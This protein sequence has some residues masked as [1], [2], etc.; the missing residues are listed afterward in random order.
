MAM[1][2]IQFQA[3][4]STPELF[5]LFGTEAL[6]SAAL[7][8]ARWPDG[9]RCPECGIAAQCI[10]HSSGNKIFQCNACRHQ[11]SL[12]S[13]TVFQSTNLPLTIW[14]L[15]IYL[16]SQAKTGLWA[17]VRKRQMGV[18][19]PTAWLIHQKLMQA[20]TEREAQYKL[21]RKVQVNDAYLSGE[22]IGDKVGRGP[23]NKVAF[24]AGVSLAD[25]GHLMRVKLSPV[26]AFKLKAIADWASQCLAAGS[27]VYSDGLACFS[28]VIQTGCNHECTVVAGRN[29]KDVPELQWINTVL[30]NLKTSLSGSYHSFGFRNYAA[31]YLRTFATASIADSILR[32]L[33]QRQLVAAAQC[34]PYSQHSSRTVAEVHC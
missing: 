6:C 9:F 19:Y 34:R 27:T 10:L 3:G 25:E 29:P 24:V 16:V 28:A 2:C 23:K 18:S 1:N 15:A 30:V 26:P 20:M 13:G 8:S 22:R 32:S 11:T 33:P 12:I 17:L 5:N 7:E 14:F 31:Q 21:S 4:L